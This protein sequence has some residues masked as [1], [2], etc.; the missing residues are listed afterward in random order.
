MGDE[1]AR[2]CLSFESKDIP[3]KHIPGPQGVRGRNSDNTLIKEK[4]G[5]EPPTRIEDGLRITYFWI[6]EQV[7]KDAAAGL[8]VSLYASSKVVIQSVEC[9]TN[10]A[11]GVQAR[12]KDSSDDPDKVEYKSRSS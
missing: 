4:L 1:F 6:K 9:L 8:D 2:I 12:P 3:Y 7:D 10:L 11:E 5:W